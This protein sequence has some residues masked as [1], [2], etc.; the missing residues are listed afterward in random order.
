[1]QSTRYNGIECYQEAIGKS[2]MEDSK[3]S[4]FKAKE[5]ASKKRS[6]RRHLP[7]RGLRSSGIHHGSWTSAIGPRNESGKG[8]AKISLIVELTK[9]RNS[10]PSCQ[11]T[12]RLFQFSFIK[13][14]LRGVLAQP[15]FIVAT[16][17][18]LSIF[19]VI[20]TCCRQ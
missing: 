1:M 8:T 13:L 7:S 15:R 9:I 14:A 2:R 19:L 4:L 20:M 6:T 10:G 17:F 12:V 16:F 3:R 18:T 11:S 5:T